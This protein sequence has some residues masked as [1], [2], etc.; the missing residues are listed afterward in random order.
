MLSNV[1]QELTFGHPDANEP[2]PVYETYEFVAPATGALD[3][4]DVDTEVDSVLPVVVLAPACTD[5][6]ERVLYAGRD[7]LVA[8]LPPQIA[9]Q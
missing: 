4:P 2:S 7:S 9:T 3:D 6:R 8:L 1:I 5:D